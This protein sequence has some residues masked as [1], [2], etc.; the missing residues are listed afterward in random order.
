MSADGAQVA[1]AKVGEHGEEDRAK[2]H[3]P[4]HR[5]T[6][7]HAHTCTHMHTHAH[8]CTHMHTHAHTCTHM[9]TNAHIHTHTHT[10]THLLQRRVSS[11]STH[12]GRG[13]VRL[14]GALVTCTDASTSTIQVQHGTVQGGHGGGG[15]E[16]S[17]GVRSAHNGG[18]PAHGAKRGALGRAGR[19]DAQMRNDAEDTRCNQTQE[20]VTEHPDQYW[21]AAM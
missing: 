11:C 9:H 8:T 7:I 14:D 6:Y 12:K 1:I 13:V 18:K 3:T 4:A 2:R 5:H 10:Y 17:G 15:D 16:A 19:R 20:G 21:W